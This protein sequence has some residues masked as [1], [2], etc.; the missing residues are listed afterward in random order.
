[1]MHSDIDLELPF[2]RGKHKIT[3]WRCERILSG[4]ERIKDTSVGYVESCLHSMFTWAS[5]NW[6]GKWINRDF[7]FPIFYIGMER[8]IEHVSNFQSE[9]Q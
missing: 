9:P 4:G 8:L 6:F 5:T 1:M 3:W 2:E 7:E